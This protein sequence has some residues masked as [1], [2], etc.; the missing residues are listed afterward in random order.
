MPPWQT[1]TDYCKHAGGIYQDGWTSDA[2][3][4]MS[5]AADFW[6]TSLYIAIA[7]WGFFTVLQLFTTFDIQYSYGHALGRAVQHLLRQIILFFLACGSFFMMLLFHQ[8]IWLISNSFVGGGLAQ[9]R[10]DD[11]W[12]RN[13]GVQI[14]TDA[15]NSV[16]IKCDGQI[17]DWL[18]CVSNAINW[19]SGGNQANQNQIYG[20]TWSSIWYGLGYVEDTI[21]QAVGSIR[22][23][24]MLLL[25]GAAPL[26]IVAAGFQHFRHAVFMR[27]LELWLELEGLAVLSALAISGFSHVICPSVDILPGYIVCPIPIGTK[28]DGMRE[29]QFAF[30]LVAFA[31]VICGTQL[32]YIWRFIGQIISVGT[33]MYQQDYNRNV[34]NVKAGENI[35][36]SIPIIGGLIIHQ[37][38]DTTMSYIAQ[39]NG[40]SGSTMR[41]LPPPQASSGSDDGKGSNSNSLPG[42]SPNSGAPLQVPIGI[43]PPSQAAGGVMVRYTQYGIVQLPLLPPAAPPP[44]PAAALGADAAELAL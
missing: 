24:A 41:E 26:A 25:L 14:V 16:G 9:W 31:G 34:S 21:L 42:G 15:R 11:L 10:V 33:D 35:L 18:N 3:F 39:A 2:V 28:P 17:Q 20:V 4:C 13:F 32:G 38:M 22:F 5:G 43:V 44:P 6:K 1:D 40:Y 27:W 30:L 37:I 23:L 8:L 7:F 29:Q 19:A 12:G 36:S